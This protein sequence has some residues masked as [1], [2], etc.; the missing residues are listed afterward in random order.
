MQMRPKRKHKGCCKGNK[1]FRCR[2]SKDWK[3]GGA[4]EAAAKVKLLRQLQ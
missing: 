2:A 3:G 1:A 4:V